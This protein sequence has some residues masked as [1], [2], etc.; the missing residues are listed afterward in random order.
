M[1]ISGAIFCIICSTHYIS[2]I[3]ILFCRHLV[4]AVELASN[5]STVVSRGPT[6]GEVR[7][8]YT[9]LFGPLP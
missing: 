8:P 7:N 5:V 2:I 4:Q 6:P 9:E 3:F 1:G